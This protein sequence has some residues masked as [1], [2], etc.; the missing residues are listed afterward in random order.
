MYALCFFG[1]FY[2]LGDRSRKVQRTERNNGLLLNLDDVFK[3]DF[4]VA[5]INKDINPIPVGRSANL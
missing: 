2:R 1:H 5:L 4:L 3:M